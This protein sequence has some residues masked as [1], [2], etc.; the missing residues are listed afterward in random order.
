MV[1][2]I[3]LPEDGAYEPLADKPWSG[4]S[5]QRK[6]VSVRT[7]AVWAASRTAR[8]RAKVALSIRCPS[9][10]ETAASRPRAIQPWI[11]WRLTPAISAASA[12]VSQRFPLPYLPFHAG[13][14]SFVHRAA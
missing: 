2:R 7:P 1:E 10:D 9:S 5:A 6:M 12:T 11:A 4:S 13:R 8:N 3:A 14:C